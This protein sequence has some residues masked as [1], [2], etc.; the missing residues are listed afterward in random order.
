V[1]GVTFAEVGRAERCRHG[2]Q[3]FAATPA[4]REARHAHDATVA[5]GLRAEHCRDRISSWD[6]RAQPDLRL[7]GSCGDRWR[8][9]RL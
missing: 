8:G 5:V 3:D 1:A 9:Q 2:R 4:A 7:Q 6:G